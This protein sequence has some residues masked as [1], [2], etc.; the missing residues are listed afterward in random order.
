MKGGRKA[1]KARR[2]GRRVRKALGLRRPKYQDG[3]SFKLQSNQCVLYNSG[4]SVVASGPL[5]ISS[6]PAPVNG[7]T[8]F[9]GAFNFYLAATTQYSQLS[10]FWDRYKINGI[11]VRVIPQNNIANVQGG[12][13]LPEMRMCYDYDDALIPT[14]GD[15]WARNGKTIRLDKPRT[16]YLKPKVCNLVFLGTQQQ[17]NSPVRAPYLDM[18]TGANVPHYGLKFGVR[19]WFQTGSNLLSV[20]F[21]ITYYVTFK[22][23]IRVQAP[24]NL[25]DPPEITEVEEDQ[26]C[27]DK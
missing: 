23:M 15:I 10:T 1:F 27:E 11:K 4:S 18:A 26:P 9:G 25:V 17:A 12:G 13:V 16:F 21:E 3:A 24:D 5:R 20:R 22:N 8:S 2:R 6:A 14:T 19:D 7:T